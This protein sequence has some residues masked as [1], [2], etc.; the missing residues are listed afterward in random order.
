MTIHKAHIAECLRACSNHWAPEIA[1]RFND[2][3][4]SLVKTLGEMVWTIDRNHDCLFLLL[5]GQMDIQIEG[6][7]VALHRGELC[8]VDKGTQ[9]RP[10]AREEAHVLMI[11]S[12]SPCSR[13]QSVRPTMLTVPSRIQGC[14][15]D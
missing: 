6:G 9:H 15:C 1:A 2:Y 3:D 14:D 5:E 10:I 4:V 8:V 13:H 7:W 12:Q 11:K